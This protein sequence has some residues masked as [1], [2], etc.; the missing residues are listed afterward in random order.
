MFRSCCARSQASFGGVR[1]LWPGNIC[2]GWCVTR[3]DV[4]AIDRPICPEQ[5][6]IQKSFHALDF[7]LA[8]AVICIVFS[9]SA[10]QSADLI[11]SIVCLLPALFPSTSDYPTDSTLKSA[12]LSLGGFSQY[13]QAWPR[14]TGPPFR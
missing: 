14:L 2:F 10:L 9:W 8:A 5:L 12:T 4:L 1:D 11:D 7:R 6:N 13:C 3:V